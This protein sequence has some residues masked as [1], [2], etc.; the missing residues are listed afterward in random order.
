MSL[1]KGVFQEGYMKFD[2]NNRY[3]LTRIKVEPKIDGVSI[4]ISFEE[5]DQWY[6]SFFIREVLQKEI[7]SFNKAS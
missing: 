6:E 4:K 1:L 7:E 2:L 5:Y 3:S